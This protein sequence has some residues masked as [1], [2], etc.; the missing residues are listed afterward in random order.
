MGVTVRHG[1]ITEP[2]LV[3][4]V[5]HLD[6]IFPRPNDC[7]VVVSGTSG[8][9]PGRKSA[10]RP[11]AFVSVLHPIRVVPAGREGNIGAVNMTHDPQN[12]GF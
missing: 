10:V 2:I 9:G 12:S 11:C 6:K 7:V 1:A 8:C 4:H 5:I 3:V